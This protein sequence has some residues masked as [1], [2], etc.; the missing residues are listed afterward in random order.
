MSK[1]FRTT[2]AALAMIAL[3]HLAACVTES[4]RCTAGFTYAPQYDACLQDAV[5]AD[6]GGGND[7][8]GNQDVATGADAAA[9]DG[10]PES[11]LGNACAASADCGGRA[12]FCLK[13]PTAD[14]ADPGICSIPGCTA[15]DCA[16][17]YSCCDCTSAVLAS[18][19]T[20]P[21]GVCAP[22][23]SASSLT[24]LGCTCL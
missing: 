8:A 2:T 21:A 23:A 7:G 6:G 15:A 22:S 10:A 24:G 5:A 19:T 20:W 3:P 13:D 4:N 11:G 16:G 1:P 18:L 12:S 17:A 14:P 9:A